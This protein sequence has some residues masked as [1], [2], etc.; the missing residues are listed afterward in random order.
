MRGEGR[1]PERAAHL[2]WGSAMPV[3]GIREYLA[4]L[5]RQRWVV[6]GAVAIVVASAAVFL[7]I[8]TPQYQATATVLLR[9]GDPSERFFTGNT[10]EPPL[11]V[12]GEAAFATSFPVVAEAAESL[13]GVDPVEMLEHLSVTVDEESAIVRISATRPDPAQARDT[14]TAVARA[15]VDGRRSAETANLGRLLEEFEAQLQELQGEIAE[16]DAQIGDGGVTTPPDALNPS[17]VGP[18]GSPRAA[19]HAA[20]VRYQEIFERQQLLLIERGVRRGGAQLVSPALLPSEPVGPSLPQAAA[21]AGF[22]GLLVG[23]GLALLR[24]HLDDRLR[25]GDDAAAQAGLPV[26]AELPKVRRRRRASGVES[27]V[28]PNGALAEAVRG[29]RTTLQCLDPDNPVRR[30]VVTSPGRSEGKSFVALNLATVYA[31]AGYR[32]VVVSADLRRPTLEAVL[33][34]PPG[35]LGL[36]SVVQAPDLH[37]AELASDPAA[38]Q[39]AQRRREPA[40]RRPSVEEALVPTSVA[41]LW[42]LP[43]GPLPPNPAELLGSTAMDQ[44]LDRLAG[45]VDM[46]VVDTPPVLAVTDAAILATGA[47]GVVLVVAPGQTASRAV[48]RATAALSAVNARLLGIVV[49][50]VVRMSSGNDAY[51]AE[52]AQT[53]GLSVDAG[54]GDG[55]GN[56]PSGHAPRLRK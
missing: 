31:Q 48:R 7:L 39:R 1:L 4:V 27:V 35:G 42:L 49:N 40:E 24:D 37:A 29:L 25:T 55:N 9:P 53:V 30:L 45:M 19:R 22:A 52:G 5:R 50:K 23:L 43:S 46:V 14:A 28:Y 17:A 15:F 44:V 11:N 41:K 10:P 18:P 13:P 54:V 32:T 12:E 3:M 33:E 6:I 21:V 16:L 2:A 36:T 26:L 51:Y 47:D 34:H 20:L 56:S 8:Q 38:D